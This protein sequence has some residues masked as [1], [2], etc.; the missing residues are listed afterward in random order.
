MKKLK[1]LMFSS[2][3]T[4][5]MVGCM[6]KPVANVQVDSN[7]FLVNKT[8]T[9]TSNSENA[10][11]YIWTVNEGTESSNEYTDHVTK[12]S[13]G[14]PC[15]NTYSFKIDKEGYYVL[16]FMAENRSGGCSKSSGSKKWDTKK[17]S[18]KVE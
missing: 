11:A 13:G 15:D 3:M 17:V 18:F 9:F 5:L 10:N 1:L 4:T 7:I 16:I 2:L 12:V 14:E 8:I 6:T